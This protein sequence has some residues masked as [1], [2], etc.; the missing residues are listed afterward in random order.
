VPSS[1]SLPEDSPADLVIMGRVAAPYAVRGWI[2]VQT[3][4]E[5][6]DN[7]LDY[8]VWRLGKAGKWQAYEVL[9]AK[10][11]SQSLVAQLDGINDRNAAEAVTG[12]DIAVLREEL[13][14][15]EENEFYWDD[16]VG[17]QVVNTNGELLGKVTGLLETGAH[18][19]MKVAGER[20]HLIPFVKAI[21]REVDADEGRIVVDWG[22]DW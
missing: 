17:L 1:R 16:L 2:K 14:P 6:L 9:E 13:P 4:T 22:T 15:A 10:V 19:V 5:N 12:L 3:F 7:L 20:E 18:D 11:H 8:P 21:V